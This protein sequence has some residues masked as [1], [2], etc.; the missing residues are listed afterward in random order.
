VFDVL[1]I[2][3]DVMPPWAATVIAGG[4]T[5]SLQS[6]RSRRSPSGQMST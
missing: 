5:Q 3:Y 2:L 4:L 1:E 6:N